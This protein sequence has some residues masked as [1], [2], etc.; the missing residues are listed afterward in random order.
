MRLNHPL[1]PSSTKITSTGTGKVFKYSSKA[2]VSSG[3]FSSSFK[4]GITTE[5]QVVAFCIF[6][7]EKILHHFNYSIFEDDPMKPKKF[8]LLFSNGMNPCSIIAAV[9]FGEVPERLN[10]A[11]SKTVYKPHGC[12]WVRIPPSP[13]NTNHFCGQKS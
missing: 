7:R 9:S 2:L 12:S 10:G 11:V 13:Q 6:P 3:K 5:S 1:E 8:E 4:K